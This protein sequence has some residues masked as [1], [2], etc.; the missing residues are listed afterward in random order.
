MCVFVMTAAD[1][2]SWEIGAL[3]AFDAF[4]PGLLDISGPAFLS[5]GGFDQ[6]VA[7]A[8]Q[9]IAGQGEGPDPGQPL[10]APASGFRN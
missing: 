3:L 4:V 10:P 6:Q 2:I 7:P 8:H 5:G 1:L 9:V